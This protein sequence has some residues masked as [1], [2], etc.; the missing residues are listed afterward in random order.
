MSEVNDLKAQVYDLLAQAESHQLQI[1]Q[2]QERINIL[3][4]KIREHKTVEE[5]KDSHQEG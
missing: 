3:T 5:I 4:T 2:I 1:R